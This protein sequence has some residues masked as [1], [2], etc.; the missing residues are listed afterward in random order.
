[1]LANQA[2]FTPPTT[3]AFSDQMMLDGAGRLWTSL[4][5]IPG[6]QMAW[7]RLPVF[8]SDTERR[9]ALVSLIVA[10]R[11]RLLSGFWGHATTETA[12]IHSVVSLVLVRLLRLS[13]FSIV[14][15]IGRPGF[16]VGRFGAHFRERVSLSSRHVEGVREESQPQPT[17]N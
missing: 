16:F 6:L 11:M 13:L 3:A 15:S 14:H 7:R 5:Q 2:S 9:S 12:C 8:R 17:D 10:G 4:G 1:M